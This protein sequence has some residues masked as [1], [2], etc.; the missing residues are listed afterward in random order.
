MAT[1]GDLPVEI[2]QLIANCCGDI[3]HGV[4]VKFSLLNRS[5]QSL[6]LPVLTSSVKLDHLKN[7]DRK[8]QLFIHR[9]APLYRTKLTCLSLVLGRSQIPAPYS[10][11]D[12]LD[13]IYADILSLLPFLQNLNVTISSGSAK[14]A[15]E[16]SDFPLTLKAVQRLKHLK[17]LTICQDQDD[18]SAASS[19]FVAHLL[20]DCLPR[21]KCLQTLKLDRMTIVL[22]SNLPAQSAQLNHLSHLR[23]RSIRII[24]KPSTH[25]RR[26]SFTEFINFFSQNLESINLRDI[27]FD[28]PSQIHQVFAPRLC[29]LVLSFKSSQ[30]RDLACKTIERDYL[31]QLYRYVLENFSG[32]S[33]LESINIHEPIGLDQYKILKS[34]GGFRD[35]FQTNQ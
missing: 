16:E 15:L 20:F 9:F 23:L 6:A 5:F 30:P 31:E 28:L 3:G 29:N 26:D 7:D 1:F 2:H 22:P 27:T 19:S 17:A 25:L 32:S 13:E 18:P 24:H 11:D 12:G 10:L 14:E 34:R 21:L 4:L 35:V 33:S 8:L